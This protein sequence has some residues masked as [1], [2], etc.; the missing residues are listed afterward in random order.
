MFSTAHHIMGIQRQGRVVELLSLRMALSCP[1]LK[2]VPS[3]RFFV[4]MGTFP[5]TLVI[6]LLV[7][8]KAE[9]LSVL[10]VPKLSK[11]VYS[12]PSS[13]LVHM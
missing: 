1:L 11:N 6:D 4:I 5:I 8:K 7:G 3:R 2:S 10:E 9:T 12:H 13:C